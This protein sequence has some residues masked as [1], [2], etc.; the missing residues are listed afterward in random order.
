M[1]FAERGGWWVVAQT[2]LLALLAATV[3]ATDG[4]SEGFGLG[5]AR[6]V[7]WVVVAGALG[8]AVWAGALMGRFLTAFPAPIGGAVLLE[9]GPYRLVRHPMYGALTIGAVGLGLA[10]VNP[11]ALAVSVLFPVFFTAK[12]G[13][14]EDLLLRTFPG[15]REYRSRVPHRLVPWL[16]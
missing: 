8:V 1:S 10:L 12:A 6:A 4:L 9:R 13:H 2:G 3:F 7:G 11:W 14:E 16:L 5:Y 15:Y